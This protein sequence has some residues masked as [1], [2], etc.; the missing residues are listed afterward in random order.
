MSAILAALKAFVVGTIPL[1]VAIEVAFATLMI[2]VFW[3]ELV[4]GVKLIGIFIPNTMRYLKGVLL[5][6]NLLFIGKEGK[7]LE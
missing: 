4:C 3:L 2:V 7:S 1:N 5:T 6:K